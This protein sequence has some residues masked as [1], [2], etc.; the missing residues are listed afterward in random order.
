MLR[1][2]SGT[3]RP[4]RV[5]SRPTT[6]TEPAGA[7]SFPVRCDTCR[8]VLGFPYFAATLKGL[9]DGIRLGIRCRACG[10]EWFLD[11]R[12]ESGFLRVID[13]NRSDP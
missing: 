2:V 9:A 6:V 12:S 4:P 8:A 13:G 1:S 11:A 5:S 7:I 10:A 3:T